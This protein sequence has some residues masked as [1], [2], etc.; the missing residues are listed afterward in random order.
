MKPSEFIDKE[1]RKNRDN[2]DFLSNKEKKE[3]DLSLNKRFVDKKELKK[4]INK[5]MLEYDT[6]EINGEM[7]P[8][9]K[10]R[11]I[12]ELLLILELIK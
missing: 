8:F 9:E 1:L 11:C 5:R 10:M 3:I 2:S 7:T 4:S 12:N 6:L